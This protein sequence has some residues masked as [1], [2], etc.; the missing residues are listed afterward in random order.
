VICESVVY[1]GFKEEDW[2]PIFEKSLD[3]NFNYYDYC[4]Y[5]PESIKLD[6]KA[7]PNFP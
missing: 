7:L 2:L 3:R 1:S 4:G 6:E 5:G